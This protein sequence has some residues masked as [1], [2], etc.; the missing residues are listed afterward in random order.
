MSLVGWLLIGWLLVGGP[1]VDSLPVGGLPVGGLIAE[2]MLLLRDM[3]NDI[4]RTVIR[5]K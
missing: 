3:H 1:L 5:N 2:K 4:P